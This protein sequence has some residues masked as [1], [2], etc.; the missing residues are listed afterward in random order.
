MAEKKSK[1]V[2][3]GTGGTIAGWAP[4]PS[5]AHQYRAGEVAV[6]DL[7]RG[8]DAPELLI[9]TEDV[10]RIDSK[11]M[12]W[13]VWQQLVTRLTHWLDQ[14][15]VQGV[16]VTHGTDTL[17]ETA[18]LLHSLLK[19][20]K[21]VVITGA[22]RAA[23]APAPD[24]PANLKDAIR[25]AAAPGRAGVL[26]VFAGHV[27]APASVTKLDGQSVQAFASTDPVPTDL[28]IQN[29]NGLRER[30]SSQPTHPVA[31]EVSAFAQVTAWPRVE[32]VHN[33][34]GQDGWLVRTLMASPDAPQAWVVAG[35]GNGTMSQGLEDALIEAQEKGAWVWRTSRCTWGA[36]LAQS[37]DRLPQTCPLN[38]YK[39]RVVLGLALL[40]D[41]LKNRGLE[42][43]V[44]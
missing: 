23:N 7:V 16:V 31:L 18:I 1:V 43:P 34:A 14:A 3:L 2:V 6:T 22:M 35:T 24:G 5:Q 32:L 17:E 26:V 20:D 10:A 19:G 9:E 4:D 40:A 33:H 41:A 39:S 44:P 13:S 21:T 27:H 36:V 30:F 12:T 37:G 29:L 11:N 15:D 28:A 25:L 38:P 8:L 42:K